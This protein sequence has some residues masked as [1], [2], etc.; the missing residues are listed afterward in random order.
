[1]HNYRRN[2]GIHASKPWDGVYSSAGSYEATACEWYDA[3]GRY[4]VGRVGHGPPTIL[5]GWAT[6]HLAPP[7]IGLYVR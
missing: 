3:W 6:M 1:M 2:R 7:I 5:V 4:R